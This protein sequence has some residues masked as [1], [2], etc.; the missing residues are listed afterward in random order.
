MEP[1]RVKYYG[2]VPMTKSAYLIATLVAVIL[3][4]AVVIAGRLVGGLPP[5]RWPWQPVPWPDAVGVA[6]W[7][8]NHFYDVVFVCLVAEVIDFVVTLRAFARKEAERRSA[9]PGREP[10]TPH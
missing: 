6:G 4:V 3:A 5:F 10:I 7:L 8:Y 2:L 9:A 1:V